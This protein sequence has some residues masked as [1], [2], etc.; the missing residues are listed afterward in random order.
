VV[1]VSIVASII[2]TYIMVQVT[3]NPSATPVGSPEPLAS[4]D[5]VLAEI[6]RLRTELESIGTVVGNLHHAEQARAHARQ[7]QRKA[8][9]NRGLVAYIY[10]EKARNA[11]SP[12]IKNRGELEKINS[13]ADSKLGGE[14]N[15]CKEATYGELDSS[16]ISGILKNLDPPLKKDDVFYDLGSGRGI[17]P[18]IALLEFG[19][20]RSVGVEMAGT[21][22][23]MGCEAMELLKA[24]MPRSLSHQWEKTLE[25][26]TGSMLDEDMEDA[27]V[28][29]LCATCFR[30]SL[31]RS[32]L[33]KLLGVSQRQN[34]AIRIIS[35][36]EGFPTGASDDGLITDL[37]QA[38]K[39]RVHHVGVVMT[40]ASWSNNTQVHLTTV[41]PSQEPAGT[42]KDELTVAP[43]TSNPVNC[44]L[45]VDSN[46][47]VVY[48][49]TV[50]LDGLSPKQK[51]TAESFEE[52]QKNNQ[53]PDEN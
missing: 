21:R 33:M 31:M 2:A 19:V 22:V 18:T 47:H 6:V 9:N 43:K 30:P 29:Y 37:S 1:T 35:V 13:M 14:A 34:R 15:G 32:V 48:K 53:D 41:F 39:D 52:Y 20:L 23:E 28:V 25:L 17:V 4:N 49:G 11:H 46:H 36:S 8:E 44:H 10:E 50:S 7:V 42:T 26:S 27:T 12:Y 16:A 45:N 51:Q 24:Y 3:V 38:I 5:R 40:E